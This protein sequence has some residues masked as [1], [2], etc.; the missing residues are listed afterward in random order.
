[1]TGSTKRELARAADYAAAGVWLFTLAGLTLGM[2][3]MASMLGKA[4]SAIQEAAVSAMFAAGFVGLY[5]AARSAGELAAFA[6]RRFD[7]D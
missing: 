6:R 1:M 5:A 2:V 4:E 7:R 3:G